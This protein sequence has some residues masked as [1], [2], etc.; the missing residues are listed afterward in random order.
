VF[1]IFALLATVL[2]AQ[3]KIVDSNGLNFKT[4][5]A[6]F[7]EPRIGLMKYFDRNSLKVDIGNSLDVFQFRLGSY[8]CTIGV[9]FFAYTLVNNH[10]F[11]ILRVEAIDGFFGG[12]V[13]FKSDNFSTRLRVLHRSSHLVDEYDEISATPFPFTME[14]FDLIFAFERQN[15]RFY[16]GLSF[17]FRHKPANIDEF[18]IQFG[19]EF[20][21]EISSHSLAFESPLFFIF[22]SDFKFFSSRGLNL[23]SGVKFGRWNSR[24]IFLYLVYYNGFDIYG[25]YFNLKREFGGFGLSFDF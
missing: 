13:S 14:F 16:S 20:F 1:E 17:I 4:L 9:D 15:I 11:L 19:F 3:V 22:S 7:Y 2:N 12:N 6:S 25:Q 21:K 10:G 18:C 5:T 23:T 24:G 8:S